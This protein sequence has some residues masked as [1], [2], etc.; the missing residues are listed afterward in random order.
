MRVMVKVNEGD[1][2][3]AAVLEYD[4]ETAIL[5]D[6]GTR[7]VHVQMEGESIERGPGEVVEVDASDSDL[8]EGGQDLLD[9]AMACGFSMRTKG[10]GAE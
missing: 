3:E 7:G 9:D 1:K 2:Y 10:G 5:L 8:S 6:S 4:L